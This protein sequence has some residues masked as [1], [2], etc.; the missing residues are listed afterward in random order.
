MA[1][2]VYVR[3]VPLRAAVDSS[4][5]IAITAIA[6]ARYRAAADA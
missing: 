1:V 2:Q 4:G 6:I 5:A 3:P